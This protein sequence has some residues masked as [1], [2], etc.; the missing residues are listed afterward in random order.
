[1][2]ISD[3]S[4]DVCSSDLLVRGEHRNDVG[5][6]FLRANAI[7]GLKSSHCVSV[8]SSL[9]N[10][11]VVGLGALAGLNAPAPGQESDGIVI[12]CAA[13]LELLLHILE[14]VRRDGLEGL[15]ASSLLDAGWSQ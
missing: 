3:W 5:D 10:Y 6:V 13:G 2:R 1:M 11:C 7:V 9:L 14:P 12:R 15:T 4:S 8:C